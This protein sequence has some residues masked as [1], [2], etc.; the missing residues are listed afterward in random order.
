MLPSPPCAACCTRDR[1]FRK[2]QI[3]RFVQPNQTISGFLF[4][5]LDEGIKPVTIDLQSTDGDA[6]TFFFSV[7]VPGLPVDSDQVEFDALYSPEEIVQLDDL[8]SLRAWI[9]QLPCC[10]FGEDDKTPGDPLNLVMIGERS[11]VASAFVHQG[12]RPVEITYAGS[13]WKMLKSSLF[14][15]RYRYSPMSPLLHIPRHRDRTFRR[16]VTADSEAW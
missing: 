1:C 3:H 15:A 8:P 16:N 13:L 9:E 14:G 4:T 7:P 2:Q 5:Q 6:K 12:W 11:V 10:V